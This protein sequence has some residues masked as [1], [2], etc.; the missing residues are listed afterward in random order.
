MPRVRQFQTNF[1]SGELD[2]FL[3]ARTDTEQYF[4]GAARMR[5]VFVVPQGGF[6][7]RDGLEFQNEL[8][9][10]LVEDEAADLFSGATITAPN[11]GV[12]ANLTDQ[13]TA[14][15]F[16]TTV[17]GALTDPY[18]IFKIDFGSAQ[19]IMF[20]DILGIFTTGAGPPQLPS[21]VELQFSDDDI[22]YFNF[23]DT[24][25][26]K[27]AISAGVK[28]GAI[29]IVQGSAVREATQRFTAD[30]GTDPQPESHRFWR[31]TADLSLF[32]GPIFLNVR[33][34]QAFTYA[35]AGNVSQCRIIPFQFSITQRFVHVITDRNIRVFVDGQVVVDIPSPYIDKSLPTASPPISIVVSDIPFVNWAQ[36]LDTLIL[37]HAEE[38][39]RRVRRFDQDVEWELDFVPLVNIPQFTFVTA[40]E[41]VWSATR[42]WPVSII[43]FQGRM[44][45]A[46]SLSRPQT[47]WASKSLSIFDFDV[48]TGAADEA[49]DVTA[50]TEEVNEFTQINAG[51]HLQFFATSGEFYVPNSDTE[52]LTPTNI[53]IRRTTRRGISKTER[54]T[55][56]FEKLLTIPRNKATVATGLPRIQE[57]DGAVLFPQRGGRSLREFLFTDTELAYR[58]ENLTLLSSELVRN[59]VTIALRKSITTAEAD[60]LLMPNF[61]DGTLA[62]FV[63]LRAQQVRAMTL[64]DTPGGGTTEGRFKDCAVDLNRIYHCIERTINGAK[65]TYF[66]RFEARLRMDAG[67]VITLQ[68]YGLK[69][70]P[71]IV[72]F[73]EVSGPTSAVDV[74][75]ADFSVEYWLRMDNTT[76]KDNELIVG[77]GQGT[78]TT[79]RWRTG[80]INGRPFFSIGD[81]VAGVAAEFT[82]SISI[83]DGVPHHVVWTFDRVNDEAKVYV[84]RNIQE[85]IDIS[86]VT[87]VVDAGNIIVGPDG[88][89]VGG[90]PDDPDYLVDEIRLYTRLLG[91]AE[92]DQHFRSIFTDNTGL[93]WFIACDDIIPTEDLNPLFIPFQRT[94][95]LAPGQTGINDLRLIGGS[96]VNVNY[97]AFAAPGHTDVIS[98]LDHLEGET[99][100][101]RRAG[102]VQTTQVVTNGEI[103]VTV[104]AA[105]GGDIIIEVGL[106]FTPRILVRTMPVDANLPEGTIIGQKK[107]IV[108][109]TL[110]LKDTEHLNVGIPNFPTNQVAIRSLGSGLLDVPLTPFTGEKK[111][112]GMLGFTDEGQ[113][114]ITQSVP[115]DMTVLGLA[116]RVAV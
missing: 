75:S 73:S 16:T 52:P 36:D 23:G 64:H 88:T 60:F 114:E 106:D 14:T 42:G 10:Q 87:G 111:V 6:I 97:E 81:G 107:R 38:D 18:E 55:T 33:E 51:R 29:P 101:I 49:I 102:L 24:P 110:K 72:A 69:Y 11:G 30:I 32:P 50:D 109:V 22:T 13:D 92:I 40:P 9:R 17:D 5:N 45:F 83:D 1:T 43:F 67:S 34:I 99:V 96:F 25:V 2:P 90:G 100:A 3:F 39:P 53:I 71:N 12:V 85:T 27:F 115:A 103:T 113:V 35:P 116:Q 91:A 61:D 28:P 80:S 104:G 37:V 79:A 108:S 31:L 57:L 74:G 59:P 66:E 15:V 65:R 19:A 26:A 8:P 89:F 78:G 95:N 4:N 46:G 62:I 56:P 105:F 20:F 77:R 44:W 86:A 58:S 48:G 93:V 63:T 70:S 7:R 98:D 84:D 82:A 68:N 112:E 41:D 76:T 21:L 47:I 54:D 94:A